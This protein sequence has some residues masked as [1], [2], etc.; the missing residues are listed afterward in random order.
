MG[1]EVTQTDTTQTSTPTAEE[2]ELNRLLLERVKAAQPGQL[3]LQGN[4]LNIANQLLLGE[5]LPGFLEGLPG[6][7]DEESVSNLVGQ[8]LE[9]VGSFG[10]QFGILDSGTIQEV[11]TKTAAEIRAGAKQF[12]I[13]NLAQLLNLAVGGQ[14]QVQA[15]L[16]SQSGQLSQNLAG[17]RTTVGSGTSSLSTNFFSNPF[18]A[19]IG[20]GFG[21]GLGA[22]AGG[23]MF[24]S[25]TV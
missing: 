23:G 17:L 22:A 8:S 11:G 2:K 3:E 20:Q 13:Q 5:P 24:A 7:L 1:S 9:D 25:T 19:G 4:A 12:N 15:P 14:A 18:V 16:F 10:N 21:Q 6:G